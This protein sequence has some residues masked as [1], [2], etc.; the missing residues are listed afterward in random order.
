MI[1][2]ALAPE[3]EYAN[4]NTGSRGMWIRKAL[5]GERQENPIR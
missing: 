3:K 4:C 1:H 5:Y 2:T